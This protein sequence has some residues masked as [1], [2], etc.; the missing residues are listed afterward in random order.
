MKKSKLDKQK[1]GFYFEDGYE[2]KLP[3]ILRFLK[4]G[5]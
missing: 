2:F 5:K 3:N 4:K 1:E